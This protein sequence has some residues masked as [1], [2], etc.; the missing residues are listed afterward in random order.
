MLAPA[1]GK[2]QGKVNG[3]K[4]PAD[5]LFYSDLKT[6]EQG[7]GQRIDND[8]AWLPSMAKR[9]AGVDPGVSER[10]G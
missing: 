7:A 3:A 2:C 6:Y 9:E 10:I 1:I 5:A 4:Y 8:K